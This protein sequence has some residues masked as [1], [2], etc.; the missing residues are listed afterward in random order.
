[1]NHRE[2]ADL[3]RHITGNYG[4]DSVPYELDDLDRILLLREALSG[5]IGMAKME[6]AS[7]AWRKAAILAQQVLDDTRLP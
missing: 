2:R 5:M 1:M 4:E 3:D 7:E 6:T